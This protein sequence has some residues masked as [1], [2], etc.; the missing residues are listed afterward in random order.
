MSRRLAVIVAG[1]PS[2]DVAA[3]TV[4]ERDA[5]LMRARLAIDDLG[6]EVRTLDPRADLAEQLHQLFDRAEPP[7]EEALLYASCLVTVAADQRAYLC[8][9]P[10]RP[11]VGDSLR[12]LAKTLRGRCP[13]GSLIVVDAR[14]DAG[15]EGANASSA[16]EI[17]TAVAA[18]VQSAQAGSELVVAARPASA[19]NER[20]PSRLTAAVLEAIDGEPSAM[21]ARRA[22]KL[23]KATSDLGPWPHAT[24]HATGHPPF[25]LRH[26]RSPPSEGEEPVT[27]RQPGQPPAQAPAAT[28]T[29]GRDDALAAP[30]IAETLEPP[31]PP[32]SAR[33]LPP[34]EQA[35]EPEPAL[36]APELVLMLRQCATLSQLPE[37]DLPWLASRLDGQLQTVTYLETLAAQ[38]LAELGGAVG[39]EPG[40]WR[41][42]ILE[43]LCPVAPVPIDAELLLPR[44]LDSVGA[45]AQKHLIRCGVLRQP[46]P[47]GAIATLE[48]E[49]GTG[50]RLSAA[51]LLTPFLSPEG[52]EGELWW[53]PEPRALALACAHWRGDLKPAHRRVGGWFAARLEQ[54]PDGR[55]GV[56]AV[57]H[58]I[59]GLG[60]NGAWPVTRKLV[61]ALRREGRYHEALEL[62]ELVLGAGPSGE[63]RGLALAFRVQLAGLAGAPPAEAEQWLG[64]ATG[65]VQGGDQAFVLDE[66][67]K[68]RRRQGRLAEAARALERA[69]EV[70]LSSQGD[71]RHAVAAALHSLAGVLQA[72]GD[73][74]GAQETLE[75]SLH[76]KVQL[77][78]T[79]EHAEVAASLH[80]LAAVL[81]ARGDPA[82]ARE[83][84]GRALHIKDK[85]LRT[86][87]HPS[88]L[89]SLHLLANVL[90][91]QGQLAEARSTLERC[92]RVA[93]PVYGTAEHA[94]VAAMLH[95]LAGVLQEQGDLAGALEKLEQSLAITTT[96]L[97]TVQHPDVAATLH[98]LAGV[99]EAQGDV[100]GARDKLEQV[101]EIE[102]AVYGTREHYSTAI[103]EMSLGR[104]L[105]AAGDK[106]RGLE[107]LRHAHEVLARQ[108]GPEHELTRRAGLHLTSVH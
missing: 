25:W 2:G 57:E 102:A 26:D 35:S 32:P 7:W 44:V 18:T 93:P 34:D 88:V 13:G 95:S 4:G 98:S 20:I 33:C 52:D 83:K 50:H 40:A 45:A 64:E 28:E 104:L 73:L 53:A 94:E 66:L 54:H 87:R 51:G 29:T 84:L 16:R 60:A 36:A 48:T 85:V 24:A 74:Y 37:E 43:P 8:L 3:P 55:L 69:I 41:K 79:D 75:R 30:E 80:L 17:V 65:L 42:Q 90:Q 108:L 103:T 15:A 21:S 106:Q 58:A 76:L 46:A 31:E 91:S 89:A 27:E 92:L 71:N 70:G 47:W 67:G 100:H 14:Y 38:R 99:L 107:L 9:D 23:S 19:H 105:V 12:T 101:L 77:F 97:G 59:A 11:D 61:L 62:I 78:G 86:D 49:A 22:W 72:Q 1:E 68:L 63:Q 39:S 5:E 56:R 96:L 82:A 6:F 81:H 10:S